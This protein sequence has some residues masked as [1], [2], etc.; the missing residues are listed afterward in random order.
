MTTYRIDL[1]WTKPPLSANQRLHWAR[2]M[3]ETKKIRTTVFMLARGLH[4]SEQNHITVRLY[5]QPRDRRRRDPSNLMPTQ[6][7]IVDA[8]VDARIIPDDTPTYCT[9]TI[10]TITT[11]NRNPAMWLTITTHEEDTAA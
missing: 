2:K 6:K 11:P 8:L 9:E 3:R 10:P 4:L 5:Y 1:P 7:P